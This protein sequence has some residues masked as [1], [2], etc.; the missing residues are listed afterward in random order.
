MAHPVTATECHGERGI[1]PRHEAGILEQAGHGAD[2]REHDE[3]SEGCD[4]GPLDEL[5]A[6][7]ADD[8][9]PHPGVDP[10]D[11]S[12]GARRRREGGD[13]RT[14][15]P[16]MGSSA[17]TRREQVDGSGSLGGVHVVCSPL[18]EQL[19]RVDDA[20]AVGERSA[21]HDV[22]HAEVHGHEDAIDDRRNGLEEVVVVAGHELA[23]L[24]DEEPETDPAEH[25]GNHPNRPAQEEHEEQLRDEHEHAAPEDVRKVQ[26][27]AA[28]L[29]IPG[30][31][32]EGLVP[33]SRAPR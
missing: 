12:P 19:D 10:G 14:S 25:G 33:R 5:E 8:E 3:G 22:G 31:D 1:D 9:T 26:A 15:G 29:R 32:E 27:V 11:K 17:R 7:E 6:R 30:E 23:D 20:L 18:L 13:D 2:G 4:R 28:E 21:L 16:A 24:V